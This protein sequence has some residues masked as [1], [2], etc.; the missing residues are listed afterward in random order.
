VGC[1]ASL[2]VVVALVLTGRGGVV[3]TEG[4]RAVGVVW[5]W[6]EEGRWWMRLGERVGGG[7]GICVVAAAVC[8]RLGVLERRIGSFEIQTFK[9]HP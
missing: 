9:L 6:R 3:N 4:S 7:E 2:G 8:L 5:R 1:G